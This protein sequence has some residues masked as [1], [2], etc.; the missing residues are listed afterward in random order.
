MERLI[1]ELPLV[2]GKAKLPYCVTPRHRECEAH[3]DRRRRPQLHIDRARRRSGS[4]TIVASAAT[5][6]S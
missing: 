6:S 5:A 3:E 1:I 4:K 2:T